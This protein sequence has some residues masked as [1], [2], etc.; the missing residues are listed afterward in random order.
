MYPAKSAGRNN[1]NAS[2]LEF[3]HPAF[4]ANVRAVLAQ[5]GLPAEFSAA[6]AIY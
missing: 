3:C 5:S 6:G 4:L 2:M 1:F